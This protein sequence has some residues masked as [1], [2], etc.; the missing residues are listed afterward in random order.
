MREKRRVVLVGIIR[1]Q[2][3][4]YASVHHSSTVDQIVN[5]I[6]CEIIQ[7]FRRHIDSYEILSC[8]Q[9]IVSQRML[10]NSSPNH[11]QNVFAE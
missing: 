8:I 2:E 1:R 3:P 10:L 9:V 11:G 5:K 7:P 6:S 4:R